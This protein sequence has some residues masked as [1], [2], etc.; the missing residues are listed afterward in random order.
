MNRPNDVRVVL[1]LDDSSFTIKAQSASQSIQLMKRAF[2]ETNR[3][4]EGFDKRLSKLSQEIGK[5][6]TAVTGIKSGFAQA[7][8]SMNAVVDKLGQLLVKAEA[9]TRANTALTNSSR[10]AA[11]AASEMANKAKGQAKAIDDASASA[12]KGSKAIE[13]LGEANV[14]AASKAE[15][16]SRRRKSAAKDEADYIVGQNKRIEESNKKAAEKP[17]IQSK[18]EIASQLGD[19]F[20]LSS[21]ALALSKANKAKLTELERSRQLNQAEIAE[22]KNLIEQNEAMALRMRNQAETERQLAASKSKDIENEI[23]RKQR[24]IKKDE[25]EI[26][27]IERRVGGRQGTGKNL[28]APID[29]RIADQRKEIDALRELQ[30]QFKG[31]SVG[32]NNFDAAADNINKLI[33]KLRGGLAGLSRESKDIAKQISQVTSE[34]RQAPVA[35]AKTE[36]DK[37]AA[38]D[39]AKASEQAE[40][41]RKR[42]LAE[43]ERATRR[44][45]AEEKRAQLQEEKRIE[46]EKRDQEKAA[47]AQERA[48]KKAQAD[49][50]RQAE[51][52][53]KDEEKA[54]LAEERKAAATAKEQKKAELAQEKAEKKAA[55]AAERARVRQE[56]AERKAIQKQELADAKA[57]SKEEERLV[58]ERQKQDNEAAAQKRRDDKAAV[59]EQKRLA[60]EAE[61]ERKRQEREA[62]AEQKRGERENAM[63]KRRLD[64]ENHRAKMAEIKAAKLAE[65]DAIKQNADLIKGMGQM[66]AAAKI[67]AGLQA[68]IGQ[69]SQLQKS[70][71]QVDLLNLPKDQRQEFADKANELVKT[72]PYLSTSDAIVARKTA[73]SAFG[74]NNVGLIDG[75]L[76]NATRT[77]QVLMSAGYE[78]G[79]QEDVI[80]NLYGFTE[81]R[82]RIRNPEDVKE[83]FDIGFRAAVVSGGKINMQD[84]ETVARNM[85]DLRQTMDFDGWMQTVALMEQFKVS[86][87]SGGAGGGIPP[88]GTMLKM[89]SLYQAGKPLTIEAMRQLGMIDLLN[90]QPE[91]EMFADIG[92]NKKLRA[93]MKNAGFKNQED[94]AANPLEYLANLRPAIMSELKSSEENRAKYFGGK[95]GEALDTRQAEDSAMKA[96]FARMGMSNRTIDGLLIATNPEF[97]ARAKKTVETAKRSKSAEEAFE[98]LEE[99]WQNSVNV[100]KAGAET[101]GSALLTPILGPLS[102][103]TTVLGKAMTNMGLFF[104]ENKFAAA[105][106]TLGTAFVGLKIAV[107]G[108][109][110]MFGPLGRMLGAMKLINGIRVG[111][112][113]GG[114]L[115]AATTAK[116]FSDV[117]KLAKGTKVADIF[118]ET[119]SVL[120]TVGPMFTKFSTIASGSLGVI[121]RAAMRFIPYVGWALL[122]IDLV[123][124]AGKLKVGEKMVSEHLSDFADSAV[125]AYEDIKSGFE[126]FGSYLDAGWQSIKL[127]PDFVTDV[128]G[129]IAE[130]LGLDRFAQ[131]IGSALSQT[132]TD[133]TDWVNDSA[134]QLSEWLSGLAND[135]NDVLDKVTVAFGGMFDEA[136]NY[137]SNTWDAITE[138]D[139]FAFLSGTV[140]DAYESVK[141]ILSN[142]YGYVTGWIGDMATG[143]ADKV[144]STSFF[145]AFVSVLEKIGD[146]FDK[147]KSAISGVIEEAGKAGDKVAPPKADSKEPPK[148]DEDKSKSK[149][150]GDGDKKPR[151][152]VDGPDAKR[153]QEFKDPFNKSLESLIGRRKINELLLPSLI[154]D[155]AASLAEEARIAFQEKWLGGDFDKR[156]DPRNRLFLKKKSGDF[157]K[158]NVAENIDWKDPKVMEWLGEYEND[159]L[160]NERV[161]AFKTISERLAA[162]Q[163]NA[164]SERQRLNE[165]NDLS[166]IGAQTDA[167]RALS[168]ELERIAEKLIYGTD[169]WDL[170]NEARSKTLGAQAEADAL[171]Y[172]ADTKIDIRKDKA[173]VD[174]KDPKARAAAEAEL[175][176]IQE[177]ETAAARIAQIRDAL[178]KMEQARESS[179]Q[180]RANEILEGQIKTAESVA[181]AKLAAAKEF[182]ERYIAQVEKTAKQEEEIKAA[183][184]ERL[185]QLEELKRRSLMT[186]M[187]K[188]MEDWRALSSNMDQWE[189][190]MATGFVDT[191]VNSLDRGGLA[192]RDFATGALKELYKIYLQKSLA[193]SGVFESAVGG[194]RSVAEGFVGGALNVGKKVADSTGIGDMATGAFDSVVSKVKEFGASLFEATGL[195]DLLGSSVSDVASEAVQ[196]ATQT[197]IGTSKDVLATQS[198]VTLTSAA[199]AAAAALAAVAGSSAASGGAGILGTVGSALIGSFAPSFGLTPTP[200]VVPGFQAGDL[201]SGIRLPAA[202]F[203]SGGIIKAFASGGTMGADCYAVGG[204]ET[205]W[206]AAQLT[207]PGIGGVEK[208]RNPRISIFG[209]GPMTEAYVPMPNGKQIPL[210]IVNGQIVAKLPGNRYIPTTMDAAQAMLGGFGRAQAFERGGV[211][212]QTAPTM[213]K[214]VSPAGSGGSTVDQSVCIEININGSSGQEDSKSSNTGRADAERLADRIRAVVKDEMLTQRRP[215]GILY[216]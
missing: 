153:T 50:E 75:T 102:E 207:P 206:G 60:R 152:T 127:I 13:A 166:G 117:S 82:Q 53:R 197:A 36:A 97:I 188:T 214:A 10:Q 86:G 169:K 163:V 81:A 158:D 56:A 149:P 177:R 181:A 17:A 202:S 185:I 204:I 14:N 43:E 150:K 69:A 109:T 128:F 124:L 110:T 135:A 198:M 115:G 121:G 134:S 103:I 33:E 168:R 164:A 16:A 62:L 45:Q 132:G 184:N 126:T 48:A 141:S 99:S 170:Y 159:R 8:S 34:I 200:A 87:G 96:F 74:Y 148:K 192:F 77:A 21:E 51:R 46:K 84:M 212:G 123:G 76:S 131:A 105:A 137:A 156:G 24:A 47:L 195:T 190:N 49:A 160:A 26:A 180:N 100:F 54:R 80:R 18:K 15:S 129:I 144:K 64:E 183:S 119:G 155:E 11:S 37:K 193:D 122:A 20:S 189:A 39:Q 98:K 151:P 120:A 139:A 19:K 65:Q 67:E 61:K 165:Q 171:K 52:Q 90:D 211:S 140:S 136:S 88:V 208:P 78:G 173:I 41:Q 167:Y 174:N 162:A 215:G 205:P 143:I 73:I 108:F 66:W 146:R 210:G 104:S 57:K 187:Q 118:L 22:K 31:A 116:S 182:D 213:P 101:L 216:R 191:I 154:K 209:E 12:S 112:A 23:R 55:D 203:A 32:V 68:G 93:M 94:F 30:R 25:A 114:V 161:R 59:A 172:I 147:L 92:N 196:A 176:L 186:P 157:N 199:N 79:K 83:S 58:R 40:R 5:L 3:A 194:I 201:G 63:E 179:I 106:A 7:Q 44:Q 142:M 38:L 95:S 42:Q 2:G 72:D 133:I 107:A 178:S 111:G 35:A 6:T 89:M 29:L 138:S 130:A 175:P 4:S 9:A 1:T 85:G 113:A 91:P 145:Q 28:I 70:N 27:G 71:F 125:Q